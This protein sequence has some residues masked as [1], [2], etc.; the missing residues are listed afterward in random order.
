ML[1][2]VAVT[3]KPR[4]EEA[5]TYLHQRTM[6]WLKATL[7]IDPP[8][9]HSL[10]DAILPLDVCFCTLRCWPACE[11]QIDQRLA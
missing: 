11:V 9:V 8:A 4:D 5:H 3:R 7:T 6:R 10:E 1:L 2:F